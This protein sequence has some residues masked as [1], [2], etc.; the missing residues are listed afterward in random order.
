MGHESGSLTRGSTVYFNSGLFYNL[1]VVPGYFTDAG[2]NVDS[3]AAKQ[4]IFIEIL[5]FYPEQIIHGGI[6]YAVAIRTR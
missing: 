4:Q 3:V 5:D 6:F 2:Q 1:N